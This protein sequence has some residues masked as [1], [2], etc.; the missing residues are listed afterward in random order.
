M[1]C[2]IST[3][4]RYLLWRR[5]VDRSEWANE[6][7]EKTGIP[8]DRIRSF[9]V[10]DIDDAA[11]GADELAMI[12]EVVGLGDEPDNLRHAGYA[13]ADA[14]IL[15]ENLKYLLNSLEHGKKK[16]LARA[17]GVDPTT[18]SRW[19]NG[20]V[21]P[22]RSNLR[23]L[24]FHFGLH[25]D[26]NLVE[27]PI[28]LSVEPVSATERRKWLHERIDKLRPDEL[29]ELYPALRRLLEER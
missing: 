1:S 29:S 9:L 11:L 20:S 27:D 13:F 3:N 26:T 14:D 2:H 7:A 10:G 24:V 5:G 18:L 16:D 21:V 8:K 23:Q 17:I 15:T 6:L 19:L 12:A 22:Q 25:H 4:V 28:F